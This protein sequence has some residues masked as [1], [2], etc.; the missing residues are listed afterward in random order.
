MGQTELVGDRRTR[1]CATTRL[2][3]LTNAFPSLKQPNFVLTQ[4][5]VNGLVTGS[6]YAIGA[7]GISLI[8]GILRLVNFAYGEFMTAGAFLAYVGNVTLGLPIVL[9]TGIG[10][11][12]TAGLA[13]SLEPVLW[14]PLRRKQAGFMSMFLASIALALVI[15][16]VILLVAT[17]RS[18]SY[19]VDPYAVYR[20]GDVRLSQ[21]AAF[22]IVVAIA[23]IT[24]VGVFLARTST[25]RK[26]RAIADSRVLAAVAGVDVGRLTAV[27]WVI[28]GC[29]AGL[30][31][32]L[33]GLVQSTFDPNFGFA[34]LLPLFAAVLLGGL[35][36]V[37]G[38]LLG[39]LVLGLV[40]EV[41]TWSGFLGGVPPSYKP[42]IAFIALIVALIARP[43]GLLGRARTL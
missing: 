31:G 20:V 40:T 35:G 37:Y 32:V 39:G 22:A 11:L 27:T 8:Y 14:R 19:D 1:H 34:L 29:L 36:S 12:L 16:S 23:S 43:Q 5:I 41:S 21:G 9:A 28:T 6:V 13:L 2:G 10:M 42:V 18:R 4:L 3:S 24:L 30:A 26:L 38:A 17:P 25:G 33:A 15:R 7:V